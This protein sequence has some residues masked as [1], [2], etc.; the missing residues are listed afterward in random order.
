MVDCGPL[1]DPVDGSV[2][3][4]ATTFQSEATYSCT[5]GHL[6]VGPDLVVCQSDGTWS[7]EPPVCRGMHTV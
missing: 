1:T 4:T 2:T 5:E 7:E 3:V 6:L